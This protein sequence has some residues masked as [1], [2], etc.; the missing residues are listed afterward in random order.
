MNN[1][2]KIIIVEDDLVACNRLQNLIENEKSLELISI[3]NNSKKA[4][5]LIEDCL[6]NAVILDLELHAGGG[7]GI[8]ILQNISALQLPIVPF[9]IVTT[10]NT[11]SVTYEMA[12][13]L[14]ADFIMYKHE[15]GYSERKVVEF[16]KTMSSVILKNT[17]TSFE[18]S[19]T[20]S[21]RTKKLE[22]FIHTQLN[23]IGISSRV[24]GYTYL[25]DAIMLVYNNDPYYLCNKI[26]EMYGK[27]ESSV[28][29]AMQNAINKAW[30]TTDIETLLKYYSGPIHSQKGVPTLTEFIHYY[31]RLMKNK[32]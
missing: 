18:I 23:A 17:K 8:E 20:P 26:A 2:L 4:I 16:L 24:K 31:A 13:S 28:E 22:Y 27:S 7:N 9:F 21:E 11:S 1:I 14:G 6:P 12:R 5:S 29:R 25:T 30:N 3:T 19:D 32:Y 15:E 10:N